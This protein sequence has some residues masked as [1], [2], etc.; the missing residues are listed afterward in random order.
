MQDVR[1][2][3]GNGVIFRNAEGGSFVLTCEY[4]NHSSGSKKLR[5]SI[6]NDRRIN[7]DLKSL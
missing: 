3:D 5:M 1:H 6:M 7:G 2:G 4:P